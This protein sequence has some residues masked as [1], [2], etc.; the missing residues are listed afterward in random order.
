MWGVFNREYRKTRNANSRD[1]SGRNPTSGD[2]EGKVSS[3]E[4]NIKRKFWEGNL[5]GRGTFR[6]KVADSPGTPR[7]KWWPKSSEEERRHTM[8]LQKLRL[9]PKRGVGET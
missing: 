3:V 5:K 2:D 8:R 6:S 9:F 7:E 4:R 1:T